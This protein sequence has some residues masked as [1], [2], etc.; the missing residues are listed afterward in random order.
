MA[1]NKSLKKLTLEDEHHEERIGL[2]GWQG[3]SQCLRSPIS[4]FEELYFDECL[5]DLE[6]MRVIVKALAHNTCL[7]VLNISWSG[8]HYNVDWDWECLTGVLCDVT[9]IDSTYSSNHTLRHVRIANKCPWDNDD[10]SLYL[11]MNANGS[12]AVVARQKILI[13]HFTGRAADIHA[14]TRMPETVMPHAISWIGRD[15]L[16]YS[17]MFDFVRGDPTLFDIS[18]NRFHVHAGVKRKLC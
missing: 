13:H 18:N 10:V 4:A 6:S 2:A 17:L 9:S 7:K 16:G 1:T 15:S 12:K 11:E 3:F 14:F 5:Y 8:T